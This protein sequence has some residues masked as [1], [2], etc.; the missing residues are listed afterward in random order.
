MSVPCRCAVTVEDP[1]SADLFRDLSEMETVNGVDYGKRKEPRTS[2]QG[3]EEEIPEME[4]V[5]ADEFQGMAE[6][7]EGVRIKGINEE[8]FY[9][10]APFKLFKQENPFSIV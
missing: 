9:L 3:P 1:A 5:P 10:S 4:S 8:N 6:T 7:P 2:R